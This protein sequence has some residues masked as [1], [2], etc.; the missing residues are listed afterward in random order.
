MADYLLHLVPMEY[1]VDLLDIMLVA[2]EEVVLVMYLTQ[3]QQQQV[4]LVEVV[5]VAQV[6]LVEVRRLLT[7]VVEV[8][9]QEI[10][11]QALQP[12]VLEVMADLVL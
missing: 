11:D 8:E 2:A 7:L 1:L 4:E 9:V 12:Y 3:D 6:V 10:M 5:Q